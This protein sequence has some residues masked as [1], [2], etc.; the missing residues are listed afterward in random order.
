MAN[1]LCEHYQIKIRDLCI[2][3]LPHLPGV[4]Q[5]HVNRPLQVFLAEIK[6]NVLGM[7]ITYSKKR[8]T[9]SKSLTSSQRTSMVDVC[10][11]SL[12]FI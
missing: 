4:P 2:G 12:I 3:G 1:L 8:I 10:L 6:L 7:C 5:C 9:Y 11:L